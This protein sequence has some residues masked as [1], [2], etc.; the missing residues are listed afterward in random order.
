MSDSEPGDQKILKAALA[1]TK[2][3]ITLEDLSLFADGSLAGSTRARVS[4]HLGECLR[5]QTEL[6]MLK[7]F[8][9]GTPRLEEEVAVNWITAELTHRSEQ[10]T[11]PSVP[12][13]AGFLPAAVGGT[14]SWWPKRFWPRAL[15]QAA[16]GLA[17]ALIVLIITVHMRNTREPAIS[18]D[19]NPSIFR[20]EELVVA[21]PVGDLDEAPVEL[22]W[23]AAPHSVLYSVRLFEVD[24]TEL[25]KAESSSTTVKV[26]PAIRA[27]IIPGKTLLWQVTALDSTGKAVATS[28]IQRFRVSTNRHKSSS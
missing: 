20:S 18:P 28:Q 17:A 27:K 15:S 10:I 11:G 23:Q 9:S 19:A 24:E 3:C 4:G 6:A 16:L 22:R 5:C 2:T 12:A 26:P 21:G 7:D 1:P 14:M 13:R 8:D 25:W